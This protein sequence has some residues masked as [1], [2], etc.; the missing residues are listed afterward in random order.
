MCVNRHTCLHAEKHLHKCNMVSWAFKWC[1]LQIS[2]HLT[3][4]MCKPSQQASPVPSLT[5]GSFYSSVTQATGAL[6]HHLSN[7]TSPHWPLWVLSQVPHS[8][9]RLLSR[10]YR[11]ASGGVVASMN[12]APDQNVLRTHKSSMLRSKIAP[13]SETQEKVKQWWLGVGWGW[14]RKMGSMSLELGMQART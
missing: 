13:E 9:W 1:I 8:L 7:S 14:R 6:K 2:R 5:K 4:N 12:L 10:G 11:R 3:F